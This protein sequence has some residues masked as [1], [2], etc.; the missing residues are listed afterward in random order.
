MFVRPDVVSIVACGPSAL[1]CGAAKA[2]GIVIA[3]NGASEHVRYDVGLTMDGRYARNKWRTM[4]G[5][6]WFVRQSAYRH[7]LDAGA[8]PWHGLQ[9]FSCDRMS[10]QFAANGPGLK[11]MLN[12]SNSGYC[13]L[14]LAFALKPRKVYL[15]GYDMDEPT[16]FFGNYEWHGQGDT[17]NVAKLQ[18]W[19]REMSSAAKQ[20]HAA[21]ITVYNTNRLSRIK[22]F[23]HDTV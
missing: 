13:A 18:V 19:S 22:A 5:R 15:F 12:G 20:F 9:V 3:V 1:Q 4:Q 14:S 8:L 6:Q 17:L 21:G 11:P 16:H 7:M 23:P 2:P 10:T